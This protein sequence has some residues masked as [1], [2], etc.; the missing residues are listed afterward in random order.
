[1]G[2]T[3]RKL[4]QPLSGGPWLIAGWTP[5]TAES[6][7]WHIKNTLL[8]Q[9]EFWCTLAIRGPKSRRRHLKSSGNA[10]AAE[11]E[12]Q[13]HLVKV[14][15]HIC[16]QETTSP[17]ESE[18][19]FLCVLEI[20]GNTTPPL[21]VMSTP[22]SVLERSPLSWGYS[23]SAQTSNSTLWSQ[24]L[25]ASWTRSS[26]ARTHTAPRQE[27]LSRAISHRDAPYTICH[28]PVSSDSFQMIAIYYIFKS[29]DNDWE[30]QSLF[31]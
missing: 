25:A 30:G 2:T 13:A 16:C 10:T 12:Q 11:T 6:F 8:C 3:A 20:W 17:S 1:M 28:M 31:V 27:N 19:A 5:H 21:L 7:G 15:S 29:P 22:C 24:G 4:K 26:R 9:L 23:L 18:G 14:P